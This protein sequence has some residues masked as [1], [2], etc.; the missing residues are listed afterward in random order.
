MAC[1]CGIDGPG[2]KQ[3]KLTARDSIE[4]WASCDNS[5]RPYDRKC[6]H[7]LMES[8]ET[9]LFPTK[10]INNYSHTPHL[11]MRTRSNSPHVLSEWVEIPL[12][13]CRCDDTV[14]GREKK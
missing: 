3:Q 11:H 12:E 8:G 9:R 2:V 14:K 10:P 7:L 6:N 4:V 13:T 1:L 5:E